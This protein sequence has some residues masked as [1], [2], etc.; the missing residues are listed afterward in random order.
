M[1]PAVVNYF[2]AGGGTL[3]WREG[4][5]GVIVSLLDMVRSWE[6]VGMGSTEGGGAGNPRFGRIKELRMED[7]LL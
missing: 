1:A 5:G 3:R 4:G 7:L 2:T 6:L